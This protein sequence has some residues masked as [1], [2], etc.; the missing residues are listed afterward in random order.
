MRESSIRENTS[1][2]AQWTMKRRHP[3]AVSNSG[4]IGVACPLDDHPKRRLSRLELAQRYASSRATLNLTTHASL[5]F[6]KFFSF[7]AL[8]ELGLALRSSRRELSDGT[9]VIFQILREGPF[10]CSLLVCGH[11]QPES[12]PAV[13]ACAFL[14]RVLRTAGASLEG[15]LS[16]TQPPF[17]TSSAAMLS[18]HAPTHDSQSTRCMEC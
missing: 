17:G 7:H 18:T 5:E 6:S 16:G 15:V 1:C 11:R 10:T 12:S 9:L 2:T 8:R 13:L 14:A 4:R 3:T